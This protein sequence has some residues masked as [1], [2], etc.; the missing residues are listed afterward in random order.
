MYNPVPWGI[1]SNTFFDKIKNRNTAKDITNDMIIEIESIKT[2][3]IETL[4]NPFD[5][6]IF[7]SKPLFK[8]GDMIIPFSPGFL[9]ST[10]FDGLC[11]K[12]NRC[13]SK[14]KK[15]FFPFFGRL[16]EQYVAN[17][18]NAATNSSQYVP[19]E[20]IDEFVWYDNKNLQMLI[21]Y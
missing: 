18:L 12:L 11:F 7:L 17:I 9:N 10:I 3:A 1:N 4:D 20:Y 13:C 15:D 5:Y 21:Y 16:F 19:Y 14:A 2:W 6:E 8:S